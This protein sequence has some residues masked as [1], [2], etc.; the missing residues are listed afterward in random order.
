MKAGS[1]PDVVCV[2]QDTEPAGAE[3]T[4]MAV[5]V[6]KNSELDAVPALAPVI[7]AV[8]SPPSLSV[9]VTVKVLAESSPVL[10]IDTL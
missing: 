9:P 6:L 3:S 1:I 8:R 10:V 5:T 7:V 2:R 4:D